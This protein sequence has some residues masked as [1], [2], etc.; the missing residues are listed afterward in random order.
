MPDQ[1]IIDEIAKLLLGRKHTVSV[2]ESVTA[3]NVQAALS[4][5]EMAGMF[6]QGGITAYNLVQKRDHLQ[7]DISDAVASN[8]VS[9]LVSSQMADAVCRMFSSNW[10]IAITGYATAFPPHTD[11]GLF[12]CYAISFEEK[13]VSKGTMNTSAKSARSVQLDYTEQLLKVFAKALKRGNRK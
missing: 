6:L 2:A 8:C 5:G 10:G 3:G 1:K 9:E 7:V 12:A 11:E 13:T 4:L